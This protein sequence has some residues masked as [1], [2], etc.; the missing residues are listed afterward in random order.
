M[1]KSD[2]EVYNATINDQILADH[3]GILFISRFISS[4]L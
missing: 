3:I 1:N 2:Y 4:E